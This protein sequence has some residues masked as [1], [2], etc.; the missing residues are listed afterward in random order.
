MK[1]WQGEIDETLKKGRGAYKSPKFKDYGFKLKKNKVE[2]LD[3]KIKMTNEGKQYFIKFFGK[4]NTKGRVLLDFPVWSEVERSG[5][6]LVCAYPTNKK[7]KK[8]RD[9]DLIF[10]GRMTRHPNDILV[11]GYAIAM[12]YMQGR[13]G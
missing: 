11:F 2:S 9:G 7:P 12:K 10:M 13:E 4:G 3:T 1:K 8:V 5:C 6:H